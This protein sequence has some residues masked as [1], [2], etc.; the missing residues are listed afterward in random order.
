MM[1]NIVMLG[2]FTAVT[3]AFPSKPPERRHGLGAQGTEKMNVA[4][5]TRDTTAGWRPQGT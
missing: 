2:F 1:A 5:F 4:A 3:D